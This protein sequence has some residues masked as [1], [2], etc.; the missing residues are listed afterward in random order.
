MRDN[1]LPR[2]VYEDDTWTIQIIS[3]TNFNPQ[4]RI[5]CFRDNHF[6]DDLELS[7]MVF[8]D[9]HALDEVKDIIYK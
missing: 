1:N 7:R 4:I 9:E 5:S 3:E 2:I 8:E 6:V